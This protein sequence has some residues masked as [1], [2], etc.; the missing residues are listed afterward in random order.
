MCSTSTDYMINLE[1]LDKTVNTLDTQYVKTSLSSDTM[2]NLIQKLDGSM[3]T[4]ALISEAYVSHNLYK[5]SIEGNSTKEFKLRV[6]IDY[7]TTKEQGMNK[8]YK[9]KIN[10][11]ADFDLE[12]ERLIEIKTNYEDR[13]LE[14]IINSEVS[15]AKY[16]ISTGN[17]CIPGTSATIT[18]NKIK[19]GLNRGKNQIICTTLD[20]ERIM[21]S[22][23][24][25]RKEATLLFSNYDD[26]TF[27]G[28]DKLRSEFESITTLDNIEVPENIS[29]WD[30]SEKKTTE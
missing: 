28:S 19:I 26:S 1:S 6:W 9:N 7:D 3:E 16:C 15:D 10:I 21:C 5:G 11:I 17:K 4:K 18:D 20:N 8:I 25:E 2:D 30:I 23:P 14:G 24:I 12:V 22:D 27:L 13:I 29:S